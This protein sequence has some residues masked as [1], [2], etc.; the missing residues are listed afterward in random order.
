MSKFASHTK[1]N[2]DACNP[3]SLSLF[4]FSRCLASS[5]TRLN[6]IKGRSRKNTS[7]YIY[8]TRAAKSVAPD[9]T[10]RWEK[11]LE[12]VQCTRTYKYTPTPAVAHRAPSTFVIFVICI[13]RLA[14]MV[15]MVVGGGVDKHA[16]M[17]SLSNAL[18]WEI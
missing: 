7:R 3:L 9:V 16:V 4:H 2:T 5:I 15:Y 17:R 18:Q 8:N 1:L 6:N 14:N 12:G 11:S 13:P 10:T